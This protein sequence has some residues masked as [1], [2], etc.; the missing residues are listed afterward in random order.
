MWH[1]VKDLSGDQRLA[2]ES[3]LGRRLADDEGLNIRPSRVLEEAPAGAELSAA[4]SEYL[5]DL[6]RMGR[7]AENIPGTKLD[8]IIDEACG[9]VR[10][11]YS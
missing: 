6:E 4:Y 2:I 3:L 11:S 9:H 7:R 10:H 1:R 8:A 5:G